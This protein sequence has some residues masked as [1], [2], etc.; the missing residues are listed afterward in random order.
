MT[1]AREYIRTMTFV[2]V[3]FSMV[4]GGFSYGLADDAYE[5]ND[6]LQTAWYPGWDWEDQWLSSISGLGIQSDEDWYEIDVS[7]GHEFVSVECLFTHAEG[8]ID[9]CLSGSGRWLDRLGDPWT[10]RLKSTL[11]E[12][13]FKGSPLETRY[14][15]QC[16]GLTQIVFGFRFCFALRLHV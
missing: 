9:I 6:T 3:V 15:K 12:Y 5:E 11:F 8:D 2:A 13:V 16:Q 7:P 14:K 10:H 1:S 4:M